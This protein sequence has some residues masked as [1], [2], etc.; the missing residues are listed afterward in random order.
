MFVYVIIYFR[1]ILECGIA[2]IRTRMLITCTVHHLIIW[3]PCSPAGHVWYHTDSFG[4][5]PKC[6]YEV[7][8]QSW[9]ILD[10]KSV[11]FC[12]LEQCCPTEKE[13]NSR[14]WRT[15]CGSPKV[16]EGR[17][18]C[19]CLSAGRVH[20]DW[21]F[22]LNLP[23]FISFNSFDFNIPSLSRGYKKCNCL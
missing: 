16:K 8:A 19:V 10:P 7:M 22:P 17:T 6:I 5:S 4:K 14:K 12:N 3:Q 21:L 9:G 15:E 1:Q 2:R 23:V 11:W 20:I 18:W 13:I